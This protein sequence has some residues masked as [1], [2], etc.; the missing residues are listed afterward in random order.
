MVQDALES[1]SRTG[2]VTSQRQSHN[3]RKSSARKMHESANTSSNYV[4]EGSRRASDDYELWNERQIKSNMV[5]ERE[6]YPQYTDG[7]EEL[8]GLDYHMHSDKN[9]DG[10]PYGHSGRAMSKHTKLQLMRGNSL[11]SSHFYGTEVRF[12]INEE[13]LQ[14][15]RN[16]EGYSHDYKSNP[17]GNGNDYDSRPKQGILKGSNGG[18]ERVIRRHRRETVPDIKIQH[19]EEVEKEL[20]VSKEVPRSRQQ[21]VHS[22][23]SSSASGK[24]VTKKTQQKYRLTKEELE[25]LRLKVREKLAE[26]ERKKEQRG[27]P[28]KE[29]KQA[30]NKTNAHSG[31]PSAGS[32]TLSK[33]SKRSTSDVP[34]DSEHNNGHSEITMR[35]QSIVKFVDDGTDAHL[36]GQNW[37][38]ARARILNKKGK[39][40]ENPKHS[41][42][43]S[44]LNS[45]TMGSEK[46]G[47]GEGDVTLIEGD[48]ANGSATIGDLNSGIVKK[49]MRKISMYKRKPTLG[50]AIEGGGSTKQPL[51]RI[52]NIQV[53]YFLSAD[54][55]ELLHSV[56]S[57]CLITD[58]KQQWPRKVL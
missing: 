3:G 8:E 12:N 38:E 50:L 49:Q 39:P 2:Q 9:E 11:E 7:Y 46:K 42:S 20:P 34:K 6:H 1:Y 51:P 48:Y 26:V 33:A 19:W 35:N 43:E 37:D 10:H 21:H 56:M 57:I 52:V 5:H 55:H 16:Y 14:G 17:K 4:K 13:Q 44:S 25:M 30:T 27:S 32:S 53:R 36:Y 31:S 54:F 23:G 22:S 58:V 24:P 28:M 41:D 29:D 47:S 15:A 40:L 18:S 45:L